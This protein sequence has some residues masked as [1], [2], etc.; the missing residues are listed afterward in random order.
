MS[1]Q[2]LFPM[3][4]KMNSIKSFKLSPKNATN[5]P[6]LLCPPCPLLPAYS[7]VC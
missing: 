1:L 7:L 3:Y 5:N 6:M 2:I 4:W